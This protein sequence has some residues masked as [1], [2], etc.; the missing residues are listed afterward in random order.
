MSNNKLFWKTI[1][2]FFSNN[3]SHRGNIKLAEGDK[4]QQDNSGV[5]EELNNF[6]KE[7]ASTL[8]VNENSNIMNPDSINIWD[9][10]E[11]AILKYKFYPSI[12]LFN[13]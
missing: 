9:P 5:A 10:I 2:P 8:N 13:D 6:F 7:V 11:K 1:K 12:L 4:Q 3:G